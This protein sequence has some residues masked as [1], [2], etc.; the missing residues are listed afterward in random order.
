VRTPRHLHAGNLRNARPANS[1]GDKLL[2]HAQSRTCRTKP[3]GS[4]TIEAIFSSP[5]A[6]GAP[7]FSPWFQLMAYKQTADGFATDLGD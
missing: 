6:T 4:L 7:L 2:A 1:L 5:T 3:R